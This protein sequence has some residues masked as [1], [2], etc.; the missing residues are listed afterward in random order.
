[1]SLSLILDIES[2]CVRGSLVKYG[3][4]LFTTTVLG[5]YGVPTDSKNVL[6][7]T[8]KALDQVA[9]MVAKKGLPQVRY[10]GIVDPIDHIDYVLSSP[11]I[12]STAKQISITYPKATEVTKKAIQSGVRTAR[13]EIKE[14][15]KTLGSDL[16]GIEEKIFE[17]K[18]NGRPVT[19]FEHKMARTLE[20]AF[21]ITLCPKTI[22]DRINAVC[23]KHFRV[24]KRYYHSSLLLQYAAF[25]AVN[26]SYDN[27][28]IVHVHHELSD[29]MV[30]R[31]G[32]SFS[33]A[34]IPFGTRTLIKKMADNLGQSESLVESTLA[35]V[36][37]GHYHKEHHDK[38]AASIRAAVSGW[39]RVLS[40]TL[41]GPDTKTVLLFLGQEGKTYGHF[42]SALEE[43]NPSL[44]VIS[45]DKSTSHPVVTY[46]RPE[47]KNL[48]TSLYVTALSE[49]NQQHIF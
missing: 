39:T 26:P 35:L 18:I 32:M 25:R 47:D 5:S 7:L 14:K 6:S 12:I 11:W 20:I 38:T 15:N 23:E 9:D 30:V 31:D 8:L 46:T 13:E 37:Q 36:G 43:K 29:S 33:I 28:A 40:P 10:A 4:V 41:G 21:V 27:Y 1:M 44:N 16:V 22:L 2:G 48:L 45:F 17:I 34:S 3:H 42:A 49:G 24:S 19:E